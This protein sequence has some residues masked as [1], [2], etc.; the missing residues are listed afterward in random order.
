MDTKQK[1]LTL[2][3]KSEELRIKSMRDKWLKMQ[4]NLTDHAVMQVGQNQDAKD[5][6]ISV[7]LLGELLSSRMK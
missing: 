6:L 4:E 3:N 2:S 5:T 7:K 1:I